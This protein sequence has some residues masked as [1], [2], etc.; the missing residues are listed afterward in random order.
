M[1]KNKVSKKPYSLTQK[2]ALVLTILI[3]AIAVTILVIGYLPST[4]PTPAVVDV[5]QTLQEGPVELKGLV[6]KDEPVGKV[7]HFVLF[8]DSGNY[9]QLIGTN[10]DPMIGKY[11]KVNGDLKIA[12]DGSKPQLSVTQIEAQ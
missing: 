5:V 8:V 12:E 9:V 3:A 11:V 7:G 4:T 2:I 6:Q 10:L 1:P